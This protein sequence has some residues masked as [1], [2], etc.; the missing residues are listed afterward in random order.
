MF[1]VLYRCIHTMGCPTGMINQGINSVKLGSCESTLS[2][3]LSTTAMNVCLWKPAETTGNGVVTL[4][5]YREKL[6]T[7]SST[8]N[9]LAQ[10]YLSYIHAEVDWPFD[11]I[12]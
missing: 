1:D 5:I 9:Q 6:N 3:N 2:S 8:F 4:M 10:T 7:V 12:L 11:L